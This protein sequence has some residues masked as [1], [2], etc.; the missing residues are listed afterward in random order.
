MFRY[1]YTFK[2]NEK[3]I[4]MSINAELKIPEW[5]DVPKWDG[6]YLASYGGEIKSIDRQ[7]PHQRWHKGG[8]RSVR[9]VILKPKTDKDGYLNV[10]LSGGGIKKDFRK[11]R[12]I[13]LTFIQNPLNLPEVNHIDGDKTNDAVP[14]LEWSTGSNNIR[15]SFEKLGRAPLRGEKVGNSKLTENIVRK[16]LASNLS[17][18]RLSLLFSVS[19]SHIHR[20]KSGLAW[21]HIK[22]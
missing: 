9:G 8:V 22:I 13:A 11:A 7:I 19:Q 10:C 5:L 15:H 1:R 20:I 14:N 12:L 2:K 3:E 16:I 4:T 6:F 18:E 17:Q 21:K